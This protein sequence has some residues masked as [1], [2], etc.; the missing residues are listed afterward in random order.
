[1]YSVIE[2]KVPPT[3]M[4]FKHLGEVK[5][6]KEIESSWAGAEESY[7]LNSKDG[8]TELRVEVDINEEMGDFFTKTFPKALQIVKQL[9]EE[10]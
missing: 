8:M 7:Y 10:E 2:K 5:D 9:S 1:M 3:E 4:T 6:G